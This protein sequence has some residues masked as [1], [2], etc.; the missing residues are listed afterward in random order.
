LV[1][2]VRGWGLINGIELSESSSLAAADMAKEL[3]KNKV[4]V[5]PA[6]PKVIRFVPPLIVTESDI[7]LAVDSFENALKTLS[8]V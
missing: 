1:S 8:A 3:L 4:L 7:N 2:D 5:V 6:G